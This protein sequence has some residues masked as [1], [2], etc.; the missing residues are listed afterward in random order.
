MLIREITLE[1]VKCFAG[2]VTIDFTADRDDLKPHKWIV[3]YGDNG[4]GKSTLLKA[5]ALSMTGQPALNSLLPSADGWVRKKQRYAS[6]RVSA[7]KGP[8]DTSVG[9]PRTRPISLTWHLV[10]ERSTKIDGQARSAHDIVLHDGT[11]KAE[12]DDAKLLRTQIAT[13]ERERGWL[14]CGYGAHRR[15]TGAASDVAEVPQDSRAA[16]LITLFHEKAALTSAERW[17]RD[18]DHRAK[19]KA[20]DAQFRLEAVKAFIGKGLLHEGVSLADINP[21]GVF[22]DTPFG[23]HVQMAELSDGY[24][25]VLAFALDLLRHISHAFDFPNVVELNDGAERV[26]AEGVVLIDEIDSHLHPSWQRTIGTWLHTRFPNIQFIVATHSPLIP[27]R[28]SV[29]HGMVIR[30]QRRKSKHGEIVQP[31]VGEGRLGLTSDQILTGP[32]FGLTSTRDLLLDELLKKISELRRR[33]RK[34]KAR[35]EERE[36]LKQ[37]SWKF[38][39]IAPVADSFKDVAEWETQVE[40]AARAVDAF[41]ADETH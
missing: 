21:D 16:R 32:N 1:N 34:K 19:V 15:L 24:R 31:E 30:L 38:E 3:V 20:G 40:E 39:R 27:T 14:L 37:L 10:G 18:L 5:I 26:T 33:I 7:T 41:A 6:I 2:K 13:D 8:N 25:T 9:F 4:L 35:P 23:T 29:D 12:K 36:E 11:S 28:V 17:L 22:F